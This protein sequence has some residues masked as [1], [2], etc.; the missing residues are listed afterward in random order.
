[1]PNVGPIDA[2]LIAIVALLPMWLIAWPRPTVVVVL[3]SPSGVGVM[4][5]T[6]TYLARGRLASASMAA[7]SIL[8][9]CSPYGRS[10][11]GG[12]PAVS[13]ISEIGFIA[14]FLEISSA[15]GMAIL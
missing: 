4:P 2:C 14:A 12:M 13:A 3:P 9:T 10:S 6:T 1:V 15:L 11:H 8:A 7:R 5:V